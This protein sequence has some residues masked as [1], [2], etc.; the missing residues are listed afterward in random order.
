MFDVFITLLDPGAQPV[1]SDDLFQ[2]GWREWR[3]AFDVVTWG[4]DVG[5]KVPGGQ[6]G[7]AGV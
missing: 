1:E 3:F 2:A 4:R 6:I 5:H 7:Q